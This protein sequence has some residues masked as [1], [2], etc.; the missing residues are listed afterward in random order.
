MY[1]EKEEMKFAVLYTVKQYKAPISMSRIYEILTWDKEVMEYFD[2]SESLMELLEDEYIHKK[3]YRD[4]E[5]FCLTQKGI[6]AN[7]YFTKR[8]PYSIRR[9]IDDAIGGIRYSELADPNAVRAEVFTAAEGQYTARCCILDNNSP[10]LELSLNLGTKVQAEDTAEYFKKNADEIYK[11]ILKL[12]VP[13]LNKKK[14][15]EKEK[16]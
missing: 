16:E 4:E 8:V 13:E 14:N 5:S 2:L 11:G 7:V 15:K 1:L 12:C 10:I 6:D 3:F 9:R